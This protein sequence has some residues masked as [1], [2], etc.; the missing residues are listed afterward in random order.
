MFKAGHGLM[1]Y[2]SKMRV[3]QSHGPLMSLGLYV[4]IH[5][6]CGH[7]DQVYAAG[8]DEL[9]TPIDGRMEHRADPSGF[10]RWCVVTSSAAY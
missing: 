3:A 9:Q 7:P 2:D 5:Q 4:W 1:L 8:L 10:L 6:T